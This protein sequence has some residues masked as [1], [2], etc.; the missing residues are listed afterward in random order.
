[1]RLGARR[2]III[3]TNR[4]K[5][6]KLSGFLLLLSICSFLFF[7]LMYFLNLIRPTLI[8]LAENQAQII[9][10]QK[11]ALAVESLFDGVS[12]NEF[13][14]ISRL[15]DG[16]VSSLQ[17][18]LGGINRLRAAATSAIQKTLSQASETMLSIP[19]GTLTGYELL[20]G[21]G[22]RL[23][24][25]L[26]TYGKTLVEFK[27]NFSET[28]INQTRLE[29]FMEAKTTASIV[30]PT[31]HISREITTQLPVMQT[32]IVGNVPDNYV[33]IDRMGEDYEGDVLDIIG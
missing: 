10:E 8:A 12:Y 25:K 24:V 23:P 11:T 9:A 20:S 15:E 29:I 16:S 26:M 33:N 31:A 4:A 22:P 18:N 2:R 17:A 7:L 13:I 3:K 27:S 28:G 30:L 19:L 32:V 14:T 1:M 6:K 5:N 21:V